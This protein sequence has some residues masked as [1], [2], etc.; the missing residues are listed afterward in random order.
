[1]GISRIRTVLRERK[2]V[3]K[4]REARRRKQASDMVE[5]ATFKVSIIKVIDEIIS[6]LDDEE[7]GEGEM[8][9]I[10]VRVQV[11]RKYVPSFELYKAVG[12]LDDFDIQ[13]ESQDTFVFSNK[14]VALG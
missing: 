13:Q 7:Y 3:T 11:L 4:N 10:K 9:P 1:M 2:R 12:A 8:V 14:I 6:I 5:D